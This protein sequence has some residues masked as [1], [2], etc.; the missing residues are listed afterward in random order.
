MVNRKMLAGILIAIALA[1]CSLFAQVTGSISGSVRDTTGAVLPGV[2]ITVT[3]TESGL[4]RMVDR[5]V[6]LDHGEKIF[7]GAPKA[8]Q[9]NRRV[10]EVYLGPDQD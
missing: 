4:M 8:A 2:S 5:V 1:N 9:S 3:N 10:I 6:V 7:D